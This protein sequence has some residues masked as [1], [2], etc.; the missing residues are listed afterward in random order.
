MPSLKKQSSSQEYQQLQQQQQ[1]MSNIE[2][3][4]EL[5]KTTLEVIDAAL[6]QP[7]RAPGKH[8]E[9]QNVSAVPGVR[10]LYPL[11]VR[12]Y[13]DS[14]SVLFQE[15]VNALDHPSTLGYYTVITSPMSLRD[16]LDRIARGE[17]STAGQVKDDVALIWA[18]CRQYNGD[19]FAQLHVA[20]C[21]RKF[22]KMVQD[23]ED[24]KRITSDQQEEIGRFIEECDEAFSAT[25]MKIIEKFDPTA[26]ADGELDLEQVSFG[27]YR[28]IKERYL[29]QAK[30][31]R[32]E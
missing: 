8:V 30:R 25:V 10:E 28:E 31:P 16:I 6:R 20:P 13:R 23:L 1:T 24:K 26:L 15:P 17:Y 21:Q 11:L 14:V 19:E 29:R 18:N 9:Q 4:I 27:A 32:D 12:L 7:P 2:K 5:G 3:T 22:E